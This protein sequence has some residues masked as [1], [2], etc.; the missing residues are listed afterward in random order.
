MTRE[1][2]P[3]WVGRSIR[4]LEDPALVTGAGRFTA[5]LPAQYWVRFVRSSV[6]SGRIVRIGAPAGA[7]VITGADLGGVGPIRPILHKFKYVPISQAV[8]SNKIVRFV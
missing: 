2:G 4:R 6:A 8:L 5:D 1:R 3:L 7:N